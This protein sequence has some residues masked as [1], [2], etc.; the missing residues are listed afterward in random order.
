MIKNMVTLEKIKDL[1][2]TLN[3][4]IWNMDNIHKVYDGKCCFIAACIAKNL[5]KL[6]I[7]FKVVGYIPEGEEHYDLNKVANNGNLRHVSIQILAGKRE[8]IG[9][10]FIDK[11]GLHI[12]Y[13]D[14]TSDELFEIYNNNTWNDGHSDITDDDIMSEIDMNFM[15][16][17]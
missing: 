8:I 6:N 2:E 12:S 7:K 13:Y 5:E 3:I 16:V 9:D 14:L 17:F 10:E 4:T 11:T 15:M 1:V